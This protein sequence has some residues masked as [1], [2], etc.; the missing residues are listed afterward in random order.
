[1]YLKHI[2]YL[3]ILCQCGTCA[4]DGDRVMSSWWFVLPGFPLCAWAR[5]ESL[6]HTMEISVVAFQTILAFKK[7]PAFKKTFQSG[8]SASGHHV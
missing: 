8:A 7:N 1:M 2:T 6:Y 5:L 3:D 4:D